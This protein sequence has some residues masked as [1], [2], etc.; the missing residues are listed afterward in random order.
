MREFQGIGL[1]VIFLL[2]GLVCTLWPERVQSVALKYQPKGSWQALNPF[3]P[4]MKTKA[5]LVFVRL[6][7]FLM[8]FMS[9]VALLLLLFVH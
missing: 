8:V 5:Y 6:M 4:W 3:L 7:G 2:V 9:V 1:F